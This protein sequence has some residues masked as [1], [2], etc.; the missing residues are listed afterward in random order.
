M[1]VLTNQKRDVVTFDATDNKHRQMYAD[2]VAKR[3][4]GTC[5]VRFK[6]EGNYVNVAA[7]IQDKLMHYYLSLDSNVTF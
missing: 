3:S 6:L 2:F 7:M 4:W 5:P 1:S